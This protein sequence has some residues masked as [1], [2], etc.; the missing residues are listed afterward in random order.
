MKTVI[1]YGST[2]ENTHGVHGL[3]LGA[4]SLGQYK[5]KMGFD[6]NKTFVIDD[7][8]YERYKNTFIT[9]GNKCENDWNKLKDEYCK[10]FPEKAKLLKRLL[11]NKLPEKWDDILPKYDEN[12]KVA[13]TRNINGEILNEIVKIIPE[14][15][16]LPYGAV[17][18][19]MF[20]FQILCVFYNAFYLISAL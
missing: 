15:I 17:V 12:S 6:P 20:T 19:G 9:R 18:Y 11:L 2:K 4:D 7:K 16:G 8:M 13:A 3:P 1:G 14:I 10:K 5:T